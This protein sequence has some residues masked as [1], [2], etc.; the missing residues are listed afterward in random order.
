MAAR[1]GRRGEKAALVSALEGLLHLDQH[2]VVAVGLRGGV[3][4]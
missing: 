2:V 3:L 1:L 4:L